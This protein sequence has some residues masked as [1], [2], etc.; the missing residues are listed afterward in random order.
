MDGRCNKDDAPERPALMIVAD[1]D[2]TSASAPCWARHDDLGPGCHTR[3]PRPRAVALN[4]GDGH[5]RV[6]RHQW[7]RR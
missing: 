2:A 1:M 6:I 7:P 4:I 5:G 3:R